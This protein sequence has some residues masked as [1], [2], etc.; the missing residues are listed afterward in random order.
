[1]STCISRHG[2]YGDHELDELHTCTRCHM[3]DED[4]LRAELAEARDTA[5]RFDDLTERLCA[6]M[7]EDADGDEAVEALIVRWVEGLRA[8]VADLERDRNEAAKAAAQWKGR[9][10]FQCDQRDKDLHYGLLQDQRIRELEAQ[11]DKV[12]AMCDAEQHA[13]TNVGASAATSN[14]TGLGVEA[15]A[16]LAVTSRGLADVLAEVAAERARQDA[17]WGGG[18]HDSN[19]RDGTGPAFRTSADRAR[20]YLQE[21]STN[22]EVTWRDI[23]HKQVQDAYAEDDPAR[24]RGNLIQ[25]SAVAVAWIESIDRRSF[26][27]DSPAAL[28]ARFAPGELDAAAKV[29]QAERKVIEAAKEW[30]E[31]PKLSTAAALEVCNNLFCAVDALG[32]IDK[33]SVEEEAGFPFEEIEAEGYFSGRMLPTNVGAPAATSNETGPSVEASGMRTLP[34][35]VQGCICSHTVHE[36]TYRVELNADA[37]CPIHGEAVS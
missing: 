31:S 26:A 34:L 37:D 27:P 12:P 23:L 11:R 5:E 18:V 29:Q 19:H 36:G 4:A 22:G 30:R 10:K 21:A 24:L 33:T 17:K 13:A 9:W 35:A 3:L 28:A 25:V 7:P 16:N 14:E 6:L 32:E 1:M 15:T 2:E 8:R 20:Q